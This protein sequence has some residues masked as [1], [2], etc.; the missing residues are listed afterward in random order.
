MNTQD[1][2]PLLIDLLA[3]PVAEPI[4]DSEGTH[5]SVTRTADGQTN[6]DE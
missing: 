6:P 3:E 5:L 4:D 2:T 1:E